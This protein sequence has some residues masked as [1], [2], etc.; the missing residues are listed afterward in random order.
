MQRNSL[1]DMAAADMFGK[2]CDSPAKSDVYKAVGL[3]G[4]PFVQR[5][6]RVCFALKTFFD[7]FSIR[8][9][10]DG[11][12]VAPTAAGARRSE[13]PPLRGDRSEQVN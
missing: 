4:S 7:Y 8:V 12:F 2:A 5:K 13:A 6:A 11:C 3:V 10:R 9:R 1:A